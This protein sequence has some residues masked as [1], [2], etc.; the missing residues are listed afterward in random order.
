M[1]KRRALVLFMVVL[2]LALPVVAAASSAVSFKDD[3]LEAAVI[4]NSRTWV[5]YLKYPK[6]PKPI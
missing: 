1:L 5:R 4:R 6:S 3:N 2:M